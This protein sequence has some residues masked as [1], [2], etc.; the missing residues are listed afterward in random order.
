MIPISIKRTLAFLLIPLLSCGSALQQTESENLP[1]NNAADKGVLENLRITEASGLAA[2]RANKGL[3]WTHNDSGDDARIFA[4]D[5]NGKDR[6]TYYFKDTRNRDWED[7]AAV[8]LGGTNYIYVADIGDN[9]QKH[10]KKFIY[11]VKE[12]VI[13]PTDKAKIDTIRSVETF[14][15]NYPDAN[16]NAEALMIDQQNGDVYIVSKFEANVVVYRVKAPLSISQNNV[17][18]VVATL[19]FTY[20]TAAD[21][22]PDNQEILIKN[23]DNIFYW[24]RQKNESIAEALKRPAITLAYTREPQGEAVVFTTDKTGFYTLSEV[25]KKVLPHLYFYKRK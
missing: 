18:E 15:V 23:L 5:T 2:S 12:P 20:I 8:T 19:P 17:A 6:G 16:R 3:L 7:M 4:L 22:S 11:R 24:K 10:N 14:I 21:I 13:K 1:F 25:K 9:D